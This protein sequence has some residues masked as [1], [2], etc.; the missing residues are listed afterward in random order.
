MEWEEW[1][2]NLLKC[3]KCTNAAYYTHKLKDKKL[4]F[5]HFKKVKRAGINYR[6][7]Q[8]IG[9]RGVNGG[10]PVPYVL[11]DIKDFIKSR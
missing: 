11:G 8:A 2:S 1:E 7:W 6:A 3:D 4:C 9:Y 5:R 10:E